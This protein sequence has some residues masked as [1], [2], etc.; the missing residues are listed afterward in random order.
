[1]LTTRAKQLGWYLWLLLVV[2]SPASTK[3]A[4][5]AWI[6]AVAWSFY[7]ALTQPKIEPKNTQTKSLYRAIDI[8]L[9]CFALA[10]FLRTLGQAYWWDSW[11]Y[12]HF[13]IRMLLTAI[14]LHFLVRRFR[15]TALMRTELV[16]ALALTCI[17]ALFIANSYSPALETGTPTSP[18][19]WAYGLVLFAL[20]LVTV[21]LA[22]STLQ[23]KTAIATN[24]LAAVGAFVL[25]IAVLIVGVRGTYFAVFGVVCI[26][27][28]S[29]GYSPLEQRFKSKRFLLF[30]IIFILSLV[31]LFKTAPQ[32]LEVTKHRTAMA[33]AEISA[34]KAD[35]RGS[36][37]GLR[38]HFF[39]KGVEAFSQRP[40]IGHGIEK[41]EQLVNQWGLDVNPVIFTGMTHTHNEYLN[42]VLDYGVL[43]LTVVLL[44]LM[45]LIV[46]AFIL[47]RINVAL[48]LLF[49]GICFT[50]LTT[51]L[52]NVNT[53]HNFTSVALGL[54]LFYALVLFVTPLVTD[55][56]PTKRP[57]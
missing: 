41:R 2:L 14:S 22:P 6:M 40:W 1:M 54:S 25:L 57:A 34:F 42:A 39:E 31:A 50:T 3:V 51:F 10:F 37:V 7:L 52:T 15:L 45:G 18:I 38:L 49:A 53:L 26:F 33:V 21:R 56:T 23:G 9:W 20:V 19:A 48:S 43:G 29:L 16:T 24:L 36:S 11:E 13:D 17:P 27:V 46:A 8:L 28:I 47:W 35:K 4:G 5:A 32:V 55:I 30:G 12:R 44:Y